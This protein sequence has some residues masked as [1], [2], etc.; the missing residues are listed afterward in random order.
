MNAIL[1][2]FFKNWIRCT[3]TLVTLGAVLMAIQQGMSRRHRLAAQ[4]A[5]P[6]PMQETRVFPRPAAETE[7]L[8][9][10]KP[11]A[12]IPKESASAD[13]NLVALAPPTPVFLAETEPVAVSTAPGPIIAPPLARAVPAAS[14]TA[15]VGVGLSGNSKTATLDPPLAFTVDPK[16]LTSE[17]QTALAKIQDQFLN[18]IGG[19][20]QNP[21]DPA[22]GE[23]WTTAQEIADQNY[24][25]YFGWV[26]FSQM[27]LERAMNS[28]TAIQVP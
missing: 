11:V 5:S 18:A 23:R 24:K 12:A 19:A 2:L 28:Y 7:L 27:E 22:Y 15:S 6:A 16:N 26:A 14:S 17:Q 8:Q 13:A 9:V 10:E 4:S 20:D 25:A 3:L 1:S 21:A